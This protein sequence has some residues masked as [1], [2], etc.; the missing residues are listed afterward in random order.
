MEGLIG[1]SETLK[2][3][4]EARERKKDRTAGDV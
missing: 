1:E 4:G 3:S 2:S